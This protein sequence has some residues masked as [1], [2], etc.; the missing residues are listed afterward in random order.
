MGKYSLTP[1][2]ETQVREWFAAHLETF[3][4]DIVESVTGYPD[5]V[6]VDKSGKKYRVEAEFE[7]FNFIL[8]QHDPSGCDFVLCWVH[9][10]ALPLPVFELS[11]Q[12][13][14]P[15]NVCEFVR[16]T[17]SEY[18]LAQKLK[19]SNE[20]W[21]KDQDSFNQCLSDY[22]AFMKT[23][24]D[25]LFA[26]NNYVLQLQPFRLKLLSASDRLQNKLRSL[27]VNFEPMH[28]YDLMRFLEQ[29]QNQ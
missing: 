23:L 26:Y 15:V 22:D 6:L 20:Q 5:Y 13:M 25:D 19:K 3:E 4:W 17:M 21:L 1:R 9:T 18:K 29:F 7:S 14:W 11:S 27:G 28:P 24:A 12:T 2:N 10:K 8:H 16:P